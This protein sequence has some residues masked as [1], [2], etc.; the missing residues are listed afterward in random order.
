MVRGKNLKC[1]SDDMLAVPVCTVILET[2]S[3]QTSLCQVHPDIRGECG[4]LMP[5]IALMG[6]MNISCNVILTGRYAEKYL[7]QIALQDLLS[8]THDEGGSPKSSSSGR[9]SINEIKG[10]SQLTRP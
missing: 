5:N 8:I 7:L 4:G 3:L 9:V 2:A 1:L 10:H 6:L